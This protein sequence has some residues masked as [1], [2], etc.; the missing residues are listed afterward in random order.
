MALAKIS[1]TNQ[2]IIYGLIFILV[3]I[4]FFYFYRQ[5]SITPYDWSQLQVTG[6][7]T[8]STI[9]QFE[10]DINVDLFDMKKFINLRSE[11]A[12]TTSFPSGKRNPFEPQ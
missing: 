11:V 6:G 2:I 9:G 10:T 8:N 7:K 5:A 3:V 1:R 12:P 4:F